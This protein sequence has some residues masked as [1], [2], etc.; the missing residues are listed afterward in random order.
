MGESGRRGCRESRGSRA[1]IDVFLGRRWCMRSSVALGIAVG[2][3]AVAASVGAATLGPS[4]AP[5]MVQMTVRTV[6]VV[7]GQYVVL[8]EDTQH[9]VQLAMSIGPLEAMAIDRRMR[10]EKTP[11][12]M[13]HDLFESTLTALGAR[14]ERVEVIEMRDDV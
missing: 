1:A 2:V 10:G 8:L 9:K 4:D 12:P 11:R 13:T 3:V 5:T 7:S 14:V 6:G